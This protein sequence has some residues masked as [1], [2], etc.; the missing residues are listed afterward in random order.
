MNA[1]FETPKTIHVS[2][3]FCY[4]VLQLVHECK[5]GKWHAPQLYGK[6]PATLLVNDSEI[7]NYTTAV[8]K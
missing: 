2:N 5:T 1:I 6:L 8:V 4:R 7:R 3:A